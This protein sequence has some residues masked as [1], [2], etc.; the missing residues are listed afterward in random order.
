MLEVIVFGWPGKALLTALFVAA[1]LRLLQ[2][3]GQRVCGLVTGLPTISSPALLWLAAAEGDHFA[4]QAGMG[5]VACGASCALFAFG[6][7]R[8]SRHSGPGPA[9]LAAT[10]L[11]VLILVLKACLHGRCAALANRR[12]PAAAAATMRNNDAQ[13]RTLKGIH[14]C[15]RLRRFVAGTPNSPASARGRSIQVGGRTHAA[16]GKALGG[17]Q[18]PGL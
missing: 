2:H 8:V 12:V 14:E 17:L 5:S 9:L 18:H 6:Y 3:F 11:A 4:A 13:R 16:A 7:A 1:L 10:V 15:N